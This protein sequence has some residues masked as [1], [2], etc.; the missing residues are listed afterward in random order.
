MQKKTGN[1]GN[2]TYHVAE[3]PLLSEAFAWAG[4][5]DKYLNLFYS[6]EDEEVESETRKVPSNNVA[7]EHNKVAYSSSEVSR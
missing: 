1:N 5:K 3:M 4:F 2:R 7:Q 6:S